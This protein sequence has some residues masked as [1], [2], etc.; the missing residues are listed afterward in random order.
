ME[1]YDLE[2]GPIQR[3]FENLFKRIGEYFNSTP[4]EPEGKIVETDLSLYSQESL[5][6]IL[7]ELFKF[8]GFGD[9]PVSYRIVVEEGSLISGIHRSDNITTYEEKMQ[10]GSRRTFNF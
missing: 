7:N 2:I 5:S 9:L 1:A 3:T 6:K 4:V 8:Y 10:N